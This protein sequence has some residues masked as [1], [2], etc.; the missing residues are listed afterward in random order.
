MSEQ[1]KVAIVGSGPCGMSAGGRA[2][3]LGVSHIVLEKAD[4][5]SDTI[6]KFQFGFDAYF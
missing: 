4:H 6:F 2:T 5:L 3:E 1:Y